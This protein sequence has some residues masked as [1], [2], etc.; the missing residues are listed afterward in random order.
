MSM[1]ISNFEGIPTNKLSLDGGVGFSLARF[2]GRSPIPQEKVG[3]FFVCKSLTER[4]FWFSPKL[5]IAYLPGEVKGGVDSVVGVVGVI[6]AG[7]LGL[8]VI[9]GGVVGL[10]FFLFFLAGAVLLELL[11]GLLF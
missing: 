2:M 5:T 10:R 8:G 4:L 11:A 7:V 9:P 3:Y 6:P 1:R